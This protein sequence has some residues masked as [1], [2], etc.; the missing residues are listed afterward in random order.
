MRKTGI[1]RM[2]ARLG[3]ALLAATG[4]VLTGPNAAQASTVV[5]IPAP[6]PGGVSMTMKFYGA[7]VPQPY[8]PD[9]D[10]A[11]NEPNTCQLYFR[12]FDPSS[13][14]GGFKLG[15]VL[16]NVREQPG[17]K[18]GLAGTGYFDAYADTDRTF[19]CLR[20]DGSFDHSTSFVVHQDQR[21]LSP[22][23][24]EGGAA[25]LVQRLRDYPDAEYGP[26]WFVNF[27]PIV[28]VDCPAGMTPTQ[29]GLKVSNLRISIDDPEIFGTTTWAH[30][31]PFYA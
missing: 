21:R 12:Q 28:D 3:V 6:T 26:N 24:V 19:G 18:A 14:C 29:Y 16:H 25:N 1:R 20:P 11:Y 22:V 31:G 15:T 27:T 13:G 9:P 8:S 5:D 10:A 7:V 23:Y 2:L 4:L 17:Y 30:P